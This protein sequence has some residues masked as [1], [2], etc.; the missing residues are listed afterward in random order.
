MALREV[1][2][3]VLLLGVVVAAAFGIAIASGGPAPLSA[4]LVLCAAVVLV[5]ACR[6]RAV[7][8]RAREREAE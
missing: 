1:L 5:I 8:R 7:S 3:F 4:L 2:G 6:D